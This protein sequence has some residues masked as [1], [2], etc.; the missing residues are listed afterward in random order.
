MAQDRRRAPKKKPK[1]PEPDPAYF[2]K[3]R[4]DIARWEAG[5]WAREN[6]YGPACTCGLKTAKEACQRH[7]E[8][9]ADG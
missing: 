2:A 5:K 4:E 6:D 3:I 8:R 7:G 1:E 9:S